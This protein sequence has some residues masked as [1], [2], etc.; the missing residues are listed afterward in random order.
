LEDPAS[1]NHNAKTFEWSTTK[2]SD[3]QLAFDDAEI[4]S[5]EEGSTTNQFQEIP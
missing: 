1:K 2:S 3:D 4:I 5:I